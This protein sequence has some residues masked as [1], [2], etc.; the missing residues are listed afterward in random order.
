MN[1]LDT[2]QDI[3]RVVIRLP[4]ADSAFVYFQLEANEG[5]C[6]YS[7]LEDSLGTPYRDL[8][9]S[10]HVSIRPE[11]NKMF[12]YLQEKIE[13]TILEDKIIQGGK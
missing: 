8:E 5:L 9:L 11:F 3:F 4:K 13:I 10:G 1:S 2:E 6:F 12:S 7:T